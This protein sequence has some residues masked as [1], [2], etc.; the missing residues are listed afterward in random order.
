MISIY[1]NHVGQKMP[2]MRIQALHFLVLFSFVMTSIVPSGLVFAARGVPAILNYQGRLADSSGDLLGGSGTTYY[3]KFSIWNNA[4]VGSGTRVWPSSA[5]TATSANVREGVFNVAIGDTANGYPDSLDYD[6]SQNDTVYLQVEAS[7]DNSTFETLTPRQLISASAFARVSGQVSGTGQSS[8]GTTTSFGNSVV[9]IEATSSSATALSVRGN[10]SQTASIFDVE[11]YLGTSLFYISSSGGVFASSTFQATGDSTFY[12]SLT[13]TGL[14]TSTFSGGVSSV[15]LATSQGIVVSGGAIKLSSG[16]TSTFTN[17]LDISEGCFSVNGACVLSG[18]GAVSSVSNTDGSLTISPTTG[19][20]VASL[21]TGNTNFWT[22]LQRFT[23]SSST[24][25]SGL[26]GVQVGRTST[27]SIF[28][29]GATSTF[30]QKEF[31]TAC[32][33]VPHHH[34]LDEWLNIYSK[35]TPKAS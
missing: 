3:F 10:S 5:P 25:V 12:G 18:A 30:N 22:A 24:A 21:N 11:N 28:G 19:A 14:A 23:Y 29:N 8:F 20:V 27:T 35:D 1:R 15:G 13:V 33:G 17:G 6:F 16:A 7:S 4:T 2:K 9:S 32:G 26:D 31:L 34:T